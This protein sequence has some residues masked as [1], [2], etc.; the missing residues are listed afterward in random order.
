[1]IPLDCR[2]VLLA[3]RF[4]LKL[5]ALLGVLLFLGSPRM[6]SAASS[7]G[8]DDGLHLTPSEKQHLDR[9]LKQPAFD[10]AT[11]GVSVRDCLGE[12]DIYAR[13]AEKLLNPASN[14]K[15]LTTA[16][17]L[18]DL[19]PA[20]TFKTEFLSV[21]PIKD[22]RI[23]GHLYIRGHGD[24]QLVY[25]A[26][27][28]IAVDLRAR[29]L[30]EIEGSLIGDDGFFDREERI[31]A[32]GDKRKEESIRAYNAPLGA[33]SANFNA[34]AI[35][36]GPG[37][38]PGRPARVALETPTAYVRV[39]NQATTAPPGR[40]GRLSIVRKKTSSGV[41]FVVK[42]AV[43]VGAPSKV[44]YRT[45][46]DPLSYALTLFREMFERVGIHVRGGGARGRVPEDAV[47]LYAHESQPLDILLRYMNKLSNNFIAEQL[48]K[49]LGAERYGTPG[50]TEKGIR[51]LRAYLHRH[52][53]GWNQSRIFNGSG[54][55]SRTGVSA[56]QLTRLLCAID[57]SEQNRFD[58][59]SMLPIAGVDGT[60]RHRMKD[61]RVLGRIRAKTGTLGGVYA[62]SG[63][64]QSPRRSV[65]AFSFMINDIRTSLSESQKAIE[66]WMAALS[67]VIDAHE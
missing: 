64:L 28:K 63:Y 33:L 23:E 50:S 5:V 20:Y 51:A 37:E 60:L 56:A 59:I 57:A 17:A 14:L 46:P 34:V 1:M 16:V 45:V 41:S 25:E 44:Y 40:G 43:N 3:R 19:G 27:W 66:Q 9:L 6:A 38:T 36:V 7:E 15:L 61:K 48:L 58:I 47:V 4:F 26:I 62:I 42:G 55:S 2:G 10:S 21:S 22:G 65:V 11:L 49:T 53:L 8:G 31:P 35:L 12:R 67:E 24:P 39:D 32:W 30:R 13:G 52:A 29:G 54:L 18:E